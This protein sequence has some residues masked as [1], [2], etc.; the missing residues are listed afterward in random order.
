MGLDQNDTEDKSLDIQIRIAE[1]DAE[2]HKMLS[3]ISSD[4]V[5]NFD[6][7]KATMKKADWNSS[8]LSM[9]RY[10]RKEK[11]QNPVL[12]KYI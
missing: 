11:T 6:E 3:A 4:T 9:R 12:M 10:S 1:I 8:L 5:E 2:F 7:A